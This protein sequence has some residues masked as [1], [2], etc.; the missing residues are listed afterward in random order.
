MGESVW[1]F[2]GIEVSNVKNEVCEIVGGEEKQKYASIHQLQLKEEL[3]SINNLNYR[4][5]DKSYANEELVG[6]RVAF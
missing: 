4:A 6:Y 3:I 1:S 5:P 2:A